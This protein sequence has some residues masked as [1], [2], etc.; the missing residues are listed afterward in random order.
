MRNRPNLVLAVV[1]GL[2]VVLAVVAWIVSGSKEP[3]KLDPTTPE[4]TVQ[5]YILALST[6]DDETVVALLDPEL[7]CKVPLRNDY[8]P[9]AI[10]LTLVS[11]KTTGEDAVVVFEVTEYGDGPF[12][13]WNHRETFELKKADPGWII[14]GNPWPI[15]SC[16]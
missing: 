3:Q 10:S 11:S 12:D 7:E 6:K 9:N 5:T 2:V 16:K 14:T 1:A 4:G 8:L 13:S 15:Y